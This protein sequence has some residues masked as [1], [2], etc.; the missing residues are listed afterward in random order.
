MLNSLSNNITEN[1]KYVCPYKII[2]LDTKRYLFEISDKV[3][4]RMQHTQL[5]CFRVILHSTIYSAQKV[6]SANPGFGQLFFISMCKRDLH[7]LKGEK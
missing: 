6:T 2:L 3:N 1:D 5:L 7:S 4:N